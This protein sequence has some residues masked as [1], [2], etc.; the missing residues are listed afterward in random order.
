MGEINETD[1]E[2][3]IELFSNLAYNLDFNKFHL[4]NHTVYC[5]DSSFDDIRK[6][7]PIICY[8]HKKTS[9]GNNAIHAFIL[10]SNTIYNSWYETK[11]IKIKNKKYTIDEVTGKRKYNDEQEICSVLMEPKKITVEDVYEKLKRLLVRPS[12]KLLNELFGLSNEDIFTNLDLSYFKKASI[13]Y[14]KLNV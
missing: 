7:K 11:D 13:H 10:E 4:K 5:F 9:D 8:I 1:K 2:N 3:Y 6:D 12:L 14:V